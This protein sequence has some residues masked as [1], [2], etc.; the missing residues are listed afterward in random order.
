MNV[1]N[2]T[3]DILIIAINSQIISLIDQGQI[4]TNLL[5]KYLGL[6]YWESIMSGNTYLSLSSEIL[7]SEILHLL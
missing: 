2:N 6:K 7:H 1:R 4:Y 5:A 3:F